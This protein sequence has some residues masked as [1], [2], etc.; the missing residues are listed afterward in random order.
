MSQA[1]R[2]R[3]AW[4]WAISGTGLALVLW[5]VLHLTSATIGG[6]IHDVRERRRYEQ[7]KAQAHEAF[8]LTVVL[9]L[10]GLVLMILGTRLRSSSSRR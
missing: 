5:G 3:V 6:P 4:G 7:V 2:K 10:S 9:G 8:P 1:D